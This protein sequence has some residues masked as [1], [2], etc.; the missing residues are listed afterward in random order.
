MDG[1]P[2]LESRQKIMVKYE[3]RQQNLSHSVILVPEFICLPNKYLLSDGN[4]MAGGG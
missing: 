3:S 2:E 1:E 4:N